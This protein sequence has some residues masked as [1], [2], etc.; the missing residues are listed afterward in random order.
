MGLWTLHFGPS[1]LKSANK[2]QPRVRRRRTKRFDYYL[3]LGWL[4]FSFACKEFF[5]CV[6]EL[7]LW[8]NGVPP[9][10]LKFRVIVQL[11]EMSNWFLLLFIG[12]DLLVVFINLKITKWY[13]YQSRELWISIWGHIHVKCVCAP[14]MTQDKQNFGWW[15]ATPFDSCRQLVAICGPHGSLFALAC[16]WIW[17]C[18]WQCINSLWTVYVLS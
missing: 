5:P 1:C 16:L 11:N 13:I 4:T 3:L 17:G 7:H 12:P 9:L 8:F 6:R 14:R 15:L 10:S 18:S 2:K